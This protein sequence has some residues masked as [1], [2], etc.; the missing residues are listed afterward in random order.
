MGGEGEGSGLESGD[1]VE[2][3]EVGFGNTFSTG[4]N[5]GGSRG[6]HGIVGCERLSICGVGGV[7]AF[8]V[9]VVLFGGQ[10]GD[11]SSLEFIQV[12]AC[13]GGV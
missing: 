6:C 1:K 13:F 12:G 9:C 10:E 8:F 7:F 2:E 4:S 3:F 11:R 5:G